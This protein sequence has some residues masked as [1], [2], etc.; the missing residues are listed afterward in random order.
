MTALHTNCGLINIFTNVNVFDFTTKSDGLPVDARRK[1]GKLPETGQRTPAMK[2]ILPV[3]VALIGASAASSQELQLQPLTEW[4]AV[5]GL[6]ETRDRLPAR[7]RIGGTISELS[8]SE[9]DHVTQ[10]Q[11]IALIVDD[12]LAFQ[13][14][15]A[16]AQIST[17]QS[18]LEA[19][20]TDYDRGKELFARGVITKQN[21]DQLTTQVDVLKGEIRS[22]E[23]NRLVISQQVAEGEVLAPDNGIVL[24][25]PTA[26][27]SVASPGEGIAI[28]GSGGSFLRLSIPE[29]HATAL[30]QGDKISIGEG[31]S[32]RL[33]KIYPQIEGGRVLA[34]VEV[35]KLDDRFIGR[36]IPVRLP[37]ST[38]KALLVPESAVTLQGGIDFVTIDIDGAP[39]RRAVVLGEKITKDGQNYYEVL[40]GLYA[41]DKLVNSD[42]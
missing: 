7:A 9:G 21:F 37:V 6:V 2:L 1:K 4:K 38:R 31:Q 14:A 18:R 5:Y 32:G 30:K 20:Q 27:G 22:A 17:L 10:G 36:R 35:D 26:K 33:A 40:T 15:A 12:K 23:S 41:G 34:D 11:R 42:D 8:V 29:R 39:L 16:D 13:L 25:V 24:S 19:A 28:I 3:I